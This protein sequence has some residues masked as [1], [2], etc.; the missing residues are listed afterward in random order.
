MHSPNAHIKAYTPALTGTPHRYAVFAFASLLIAL[1][2]SPA[3]ALRANLRGDLARLE[4]M[5]HYEEALF[6]RQSTV[7][8]VLAIH[9]A[10]SGAAYDPA[11]ERIFGETRTDRRYWNLINHQK[12]PITALLTKAR[13][14]PDQLDRLDERVRVYVEDHLSPDYD[15]MG[16]FYFRRKAQVM[17]RLGL[18]YDASF[19]RRLTGYY[20]QR[21]CAPYYATMAD[22]LDQK[23]KTSLA[24]AYR[25]KSIWYQAEALREFRRSNGDRLISQLQL[26]NAQQ[27]IDKTQ[28]VNLLELARQSKD[29]DA[30]FAAELALGDL[31]QASPQSV[32][33]PPGVQPGIRA[34]YFTSPDQPS[35]AADKILPAADLGFR[36]NERFPDKLRATW[37]KDDIFP[38]N[39]TGQFLVHL[40]G[41]IRIPAPGKYR[42]Y[43][44]T[45]SGNRAIVRVNGQPVISPRNDRQLLYSMQIDYAGQTLTRVDFSPEIQLKQD[46]ADIE[47]EYKGPE[48]NGKYGTPG[49]RLSWS[50]DGHVM[51]PV[52]SSAFFHEAN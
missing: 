22:E 47:I 5:G 6:Y 40:T 11:M 45:D 46:L 20:E 35:P 9:V 34:R 13:L 49:L 31:G 18:F 4:E 52:P 1:C 50:S 32:L 37:E 30:R 25:A 14:N 42:F 48:A 3:H 41:K 44:R 21:V 51:E 29:A 36:G 33:P 39:A 12:R 23:G 16:N 19:R 38:S 28:I 7:D 15:E 43:A 2:A 24:A 27:Q 8:M 17:E 26:N 10:W